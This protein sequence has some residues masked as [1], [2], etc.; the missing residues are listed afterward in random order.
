MENQTAIS[1]QLERIPDES[2][3]SLHSFEHAQRVAKMLASST[4]VPKDFQGSVQN[5]MI[6]M[7]IANR[8]EASPFMVMQNMFIINGRPSW[9]SA[10]II[11]AL[12]S[13]KKFSPL[14]FSLT[15]EGEKMECFAWCYELS[16]GEKII[17]PTVSIAMAIAEGWYKKSGSKWPN[18]P[19]LMLR[20]RAAAFFGRLYAPELLLGMHAA[21]EIQDIQGEVITSTQAPGAEPS[22]PVIVST[23]ENET[24]YK[25]LEVLY[26]EKRPLLNAAELEHARR[27]I[28]NKE[29][30]SYKKLHSFLTSKTV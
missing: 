1:T 8:I 19:T 15:G 30:A 25:I 13:C 5:V 7:E 11:A 24:L 12:N 6:A 14:R 26:E 18:M 23:D 21:E 10:F 16:N 4:L 22:G 27:I 3:F 17:G 20:Y 28:G 9:S 29:V 2:V